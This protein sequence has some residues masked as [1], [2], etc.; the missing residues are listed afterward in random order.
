MLARRRAVSRLGDRKMSYVSALRCEGGIVLCADTQETI[1]DEK[2][3]CEK[4]TIGSDQ[5]Y[6]VAIGG[7]GI[8]EIIDP[9]AQELCDSL[10]SERPKN[11]KALLSHIKRCILKVFKEDV[12]V[13]VIPK[14]YRTCEILVAAKAPEETHIS[15]FR[16]KGKRV[17][18]LDSAFAIVGFATAANFSLLKSFY[19]HGLSMHQAVLLAS[20]VVAHSKA[21]NEGV[22]FDTRIAIVANNGA[23]LEHARIIENVEARAKEFLAETNALFL[24]AADLSI[25]TETLSGALDQFKTKILDLRKKYLESV[26]RLSFERDFLVKHNSP[27]SILPVGS[28]ATLYLEGAVTLEE[29]SLRATRFEQISEKISWGG[30][31][32]AKGPPIGREIPVT[33]DSEETLPSYS[34]ECTCELCRSP[35]THDQTIQASQPES[36][37]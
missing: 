7:A 33:L 5:S 30:R 31:T 32:L 36:K 11:E 1:E 16:I 13:A 25:R 37:E 20:Y 8:G 23:Y 28:I 2:Q 24:K 12:P 14:Q 19:R 34:K 26:A 10:P 3:Y 29:S 9:F 4:L 15:L 18:V 6:P 21:I 22:G 27:Y 17:S 35:H